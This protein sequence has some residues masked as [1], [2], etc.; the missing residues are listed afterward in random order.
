[1]SGPTTLLPFQ[2]TTMTGAQLAAAKD[3][4]FKT[5]PP[6][7]GTAS[8]TVPIRRRPSLVNHQDRPG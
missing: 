5:V 3:C 1:M 2:P 8:G 6:N 7:Q 4:T